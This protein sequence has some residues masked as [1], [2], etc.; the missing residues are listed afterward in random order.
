MVTTTV[1]NGDQFIYVSS[2][3]FLLFQSVLLDDSSDLKQYLNI[4]Y[5][6]WKTLGIPVY[7][8]TVQETSS[9]SRSAV[10]PLTVVV[11]DTSQWN[12][13]TNGALDPTGAYQ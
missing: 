4:T 8:A 12:G 1:N 5:N 2:K 9:Q 6:Q 13:Y 7:L 11:G 10:N 3:S